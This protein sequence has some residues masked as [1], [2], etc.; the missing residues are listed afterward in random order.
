ML[1][2]YYHDWIDAFLSCFFYSNDESKLTQ[3]SFIWKEMIIFAEEHWNAKNYD[4]LNLQL[5]LLGIYSRESFWTD[6]KFAPIIDGLSLFYT[7][8]ANI[9]INKYNYI[10]NYIAFCASTAGAPLLKDSLPLI[11]ET[12]ESIYLRDNEATSSLSAQLCKEIWTNHRT[13]IKENHDLNDAF[14]RIL[15]KSISLG[16]REALDLQNDI[17]NSSE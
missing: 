3:F 14:F 17:N 5:R 8:W 12:L 15:S 6:A 7:K 1:D 16:S 9:F 4:M 13:L 11:A 10:N 2:S